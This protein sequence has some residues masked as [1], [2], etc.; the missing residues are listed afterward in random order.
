MK[1]ITYNVN[2]IR[3]VISKG[4]TEWLKNSNPDVLC[5]QELK[6]NPEQF[7][8]K[9]FNDLGYNLYI[10]PAIKK[11]YSGVA[12]FSKFKPDN[13]YY[14][15]GIEE[16]DNEGRYIAVKH[17][18]ILFISCY[19]PSGTS[20]DE[21]QLFKYKFLADLDFFF[22]NLAGSNTKIILSGDYN[23]C[24]EAIDI[25]DPIGNK[26]SSGFLP[27]EREWLDVFIKSGMIDVFRHLNKEPHNYTWWSQR[28]GA[29]KNNKGWR[30][31]YHCI[32]KSL[33]PLV[34]ECN[35]LSEIT[36]SDHCPVELKINI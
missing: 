15:M 13:I 5:L 21:R 32:S 10:K 31:D 35:I 28:S 11:G 1:I 8:H 25:H 7:D 17:Y 29:R 3:S 19:F 16:Y 4:F 22:K 23:I 20:G 12:I 2:G 18:D 30:I 24:H 6:A 14:S 33:V 26:K 27:K 9:P 34:K 36:F